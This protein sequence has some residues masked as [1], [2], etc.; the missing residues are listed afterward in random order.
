MHRKS[1]ADG[2]QISREAYR[3]VKRM[4]KVLYGEPT[5]TYN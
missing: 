2:T 5:W 4:E 3:R 1:R